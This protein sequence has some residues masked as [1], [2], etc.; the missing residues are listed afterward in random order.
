M[1]PNKMNSRAQ[2]FFNATQAA[3]RQSMP[4]I[5]AQD[6]D[7]T[8]VFIYDVIGGFFGVDTGEIVKE[9]A[10]IETP[11]ITVR[12]NSPGGGVFDGV[13]IYNA[14]VN[15]DAKI[16]TQI[17]GVAASIASVVAMAGEDVH[18]NLGTQFMIHKPM[19]FSGG[20]ADDL[21]SMADLLDKVEDSI[22]DIYTS[23][24]DLS[25]DE[26]ATAMAAETWYTPEEALE[27]GFVTSITEAP[28]VENR[29]N[30]SAI[31][32]NVPADLRVDPTV[33][34]VEVALRGIGMSRSV[35]ERAAVAAIATQIPKGEPSGEDQGEPELLAAFDRLD[36]QIR[37][38]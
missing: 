9:I 6:E 10:A 28:A 34:D 33:R 1:N 35:A 27:A 11:E 38:K 4:F 20:N 17:D 31:F 24:S 21:R 25:R 23:K 5:V 14:L 13:A 12:I 16:T 7:T 37:S 32:E 29:F 22:I 8:E 3:P 26:I 18:M 36:T 2:R 30:L 15:H 19:A